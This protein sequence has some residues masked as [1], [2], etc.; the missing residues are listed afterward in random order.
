MS[1]RPPEDTPASLP[2]RSPQPSHA[3]I[4][5][6]PRTAF[7]AR[8]ALHSSSTVV[9][10]SYLPAPGLKRRP[11]Q[12]RAPSPTTPR[13]KPKAWG[14]HLEG[15][16]ARVLPSSSRP[17]VAGCAVHR[18]DR[19][20]CGGR[21]LTLS[22][23]ALSVREEGEER[24][25]GASK[26]RKWRGRDGGEELSGWAR[27]QERVGARAWELY[28]IARSL[29]GHGPTLGLRQPFREDSLAFG[30][31][32][33]PDPS[34]GRPL[35]TRHA[36]TGRWSSANFKLSADARIPTSIDE[37]AGT[38]FLWKRRP[39]GRTSDVSSVHDCL[40]SE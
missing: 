33:V 22:R 1:A 20:R 12:S 24:E 2:V 9:P 25:K 35:V 40:G 5:R 14:A 26:D 34:L 38:L 3:G 18:L 19:R 37:E 13:M 31:P 10:R 17:A 16:I 6:P 7:P 15:M 23:G 11:I 30:S 4:F 8:P 32:L 29:L 28:E 21:T 39:D 27:R 36:Q